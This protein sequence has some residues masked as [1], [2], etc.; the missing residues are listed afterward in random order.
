MNKKKLITQGTQKTKR[1]K[2]WAEKERK[3]DLRRSP[4]NK[5][6]DWKLSRKRKKIKKIDLTRCTKTNKQIDL[7]M[8]KKK[9]K[10]NRYKNEHKK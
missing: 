8:N 2:K 9:K 3:E 5:Q 10:E 4:K 1:P 6:V 7:T